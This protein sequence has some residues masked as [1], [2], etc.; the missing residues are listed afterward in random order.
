MRFQVLPI[1]ALPLFPGLCLGATHLS[2]GVGLSTV[3]LWS[4]EP[5]G[6]PGPKRVSGSH[7]LEDAH[8][9]WS[10]AVPA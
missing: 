4:G 9:Q 3:R 7:G 5:W 2:L 1:H 8:A 6:T 10:H